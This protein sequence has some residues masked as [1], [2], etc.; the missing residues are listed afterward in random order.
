MASVQRES[1]SFYRRNYMRAL[2]RDIAVDR[3]SAASWVT[4]S[5][6]AAT[7]DWT[8]MVLFTLSF[9]GC[10]LFFG[11]LFL[12]D[13]RVPLTPWYQWREERMLRKQYEHFRG[14]SHAHKN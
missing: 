2:R 6:L 10:W 5:G 14:E 1:S 7:H 13:K 3:I 9:A 11:A 8:T 12:R 4:A